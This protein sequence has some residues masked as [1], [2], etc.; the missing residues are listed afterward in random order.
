MADA[1]TTA[2]AASVDA[3]LKRVADVQQRADAVQLLAIMQQVTGQPPRMWGATMIG[4]GQYH[5][6]YASGHEGDMFLAG[7]SPRKARS[8]CIL[9]R[10]SKSDCR[11]SSSSSV[12]SNRAKA[13]STSSGWRTWI[14]RCSAR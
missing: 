9:W 6:E 1:K 10:V 7:F 12:N 3:F 5:Y 14:W 8:S 11:P 2:S 4:F 13:V